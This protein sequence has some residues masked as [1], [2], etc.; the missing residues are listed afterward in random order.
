LTAEQLSRAERGWCGTVRKRGLYDIDE[1]RACSPGMMRL[2]ETR[3]DAE[4]TFD[5]FIAT[6][7]IKYVK[8]ADCLIKNRQALLAYC[9]FPGGRK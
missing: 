8:A 6:Y 4:A 7:G 9:D 2:A 3:S 1:A 5:A